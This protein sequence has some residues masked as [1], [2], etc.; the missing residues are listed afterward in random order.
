MCTELGAVPVDEDRFDS[1]PR[2]HPHSCRI[3]GRGRADGLHVSARG[4]CPDCSEARYLA[5][6][7]QLQEHDGPFFDYWRMRSLA[8]FGVPLELLDAMLPSSDTPG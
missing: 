2:R 8:A 7:R 6:H 3:C 1:M 4:L 5:N